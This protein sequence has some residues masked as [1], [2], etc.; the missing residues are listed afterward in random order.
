MN[1]QNSAR[2]ALLLFAFTGGCGSSGDS[3]SASQGAPSSGSGAGATTGTGAGSG[4]TVGGGGGTSTASTGGGTSGESSASGASTA[5][6]TDTATGT[7]SSG[8]GTGSGASS[9]GTGPTGS[10]PDGGGS[11][12][13]SSASG[14]GGAGGAS[15]GDAGMRASDAALDPLGEDMPSAGPAPDPATLAVCTGTSPITCHFPMDAPGNYAVT[16]ELGGAAAAVTEVAAEAERAMLTYV[17]TAAGETK[18]YSFVVNEREPESEPAENVSAGTNGLDLYF[19]GSAGGPGDTAY[20]GATVPPLLTGLGIAPL[21]A[22]MMIYVAGDSTTCDQPSSAFAGWAQMLPEYF[23]YPVSIANYADSGESSASFRGNPKLWGN[24]TSRWVSGDWVLI[25]FGHNDKTTTTTDFHTNMTFYVQQ[26]LA[27]GV[28]PILVT[29]PSR[30]SFNGNTLG[31][32]FM[33]GTPLDVVAVDKQVAMENSVPLVDLTALTTTW[34]NKIGPTGW[35]AFHA[36][37]TDV[38][39]TNRPGGL[40]IAG[41]FAQNVLDQ[42]LGLASYL[43]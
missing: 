15:S 22:P 30:A 5:I 6:G 41:L 26:A 35:K 21:A 40:Y 31:P 2:V 25:Q 33:Y 1:I 14:T 29:P 27:K 24:I 18:R 7:G 10:S 28:H 43:R 11:G 8:P 4:S 39:H 17:P 32:Q 42:G 16:V 38:T 19:Y 3:G 37:G 13:G 23:D 9:A 20:P 12:S 36:G 34:Y